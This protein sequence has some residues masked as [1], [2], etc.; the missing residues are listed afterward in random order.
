[1]KLKGKV[2]LITGG[3]SGFGRAIAILF[4]KEGA[5]ISVVDINTESGRET[6][7]LI[8]QNNG[9]AQ[10]I[11]ADVARAPD[12]DRMIT[13]TVDLCT[14]LDIL[15]N[16]AGMPM[17]STPIE[18]V[19]EDFFDRIMS[20][21]LKSIFLGCKYATPIMKKQNGG[22]IINTASISAVRPRPGL[23]AYTASKGGAIA[24]TKAMA[25]ELAPDNIRVNAISPVAAN[26]PMFPGFIGDPNVNIDE[27]VQL[28]AA[29]IPL[30]KLAVPEDVAYA[31]LYLAS[32]EASIV[33]GINLEV[34]G[35]R[36]I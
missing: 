16:N 29:T 9:N 35:G 28:V 8:K 13:E 27:A 18:E 20:I 22:V 14:K 30:G 31:A 21:N 19:E 10:F 33:T 11:L 6:V 4:A 3:G 32:D 12:V 25:I 36:G 26:T 7:D 34:D 2:A 24:L 17:S 1:M 15:V 5:R 23:S